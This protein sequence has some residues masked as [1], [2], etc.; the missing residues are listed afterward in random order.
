MQIQSKAKQ[1]PRARGA[2]SQT[3]PET[4]AVSEMRYRRLFEAARDGI[5]L[6]N[7]KTAQIEDANPF[8]T[9]LLGYSHAELLGKKLWEVGAFNDVVENQE[10]F[11]E[12]QTRGFVRYDDLPLRTK[13]GEKVPVE[14]VSN[15][16]DCAGITVIQCNIRDISARKRAEE[17]INELAFYDPL[18]QLPNRTLLLDRLQQ[19]II[20]SARNSSYGAVLFLDLDHFKTLNDTLGHDKGDLLLQQVA[21]RLTACIRE[22]DTVARLGGDEFVVVLESLHTHQ[23]EASNQAKDVGEKILAALNQPYTL[24][25]VEYRSTASIGA[26]LFSGSTEPIEDLLKQADLAMYKSKEVGR[27]GLQFFDPA[28]Q[29]A[30]IERA[31][32]EKEL[33]LAITENEFVLHFQPQ[34]VGDGR[35]MGAEVLVRWKHPVRG[36][37][38][39]GDFIP[40]AEETGLIVPLGQ[41]V[42]RAACEQL[43][44]WAN[45]ANTQHLTL[46]VNVSAHQFRR[47]DFV[48]QVL[49]ALSSTG[50]SAT[51]LKLELTESLL[52]DNMPSVIEKMFILKAKGVGFSLDDFGTGYSSLAYLKRMPLDELKIDRSFVRDI[53]SDHHDASIAKTI[54]AL[55]QSLGL[56][57]IAEGVEIE[58][59][60][61]FLNAA[62]CHAYQGYL[63]SKPL[64]V[65]GFERYAR[66][67]F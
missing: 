43:A 8:F 24:E 4:L 20:V 21:Q 56:N 9:E 28:M 67:S 39:P 48:E 64:P 59:Q 52:V 55:A 5:V 34:V 23:R 11:S 29:S 17:K 38:A 65:A 51:R 58:A 33:R 7:A 3:P 27:N 22:G 6:L 12:L 47:P 50:A 18:T 41:W 54:I 60:R 46:A 45:N 25:D 36:L 30:I 35:A 61:D 15:T 14:F 40:L 16:Y 13:S 10:K 37:V 57:V 63:F 53:L 19:A 62:T 32:L 66:R 1:A 2:L 31:T 49:A 44:R 42:L 26:T